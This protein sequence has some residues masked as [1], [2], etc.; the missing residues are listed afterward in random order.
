MAL[1][2]PEEELVST[3]EFLALNIEAIRTLLLR[4]G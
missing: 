3:Q 2:N 4:F 1:I